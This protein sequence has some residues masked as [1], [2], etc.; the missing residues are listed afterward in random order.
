MIKLVKL[1]Y[2][3]T[4]LV[5]LQRDMVGTLKLSEGIKVDLYQSTEMTLDSVM[6]YIIFA[7][8]SLK[9]YGQADIVPPGLSLK[10]ATVI[11]TPIAMDIF[12]QCS[13]LN[14]ISSSIT[15]PLYCLTIT[16]RRQ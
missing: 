4:K 13:L 12:Q 9:C 10:S 11:A 3:T 15:L 6:L 7:H 2:E 1:C 5:Y 16:S 14:S 8:D